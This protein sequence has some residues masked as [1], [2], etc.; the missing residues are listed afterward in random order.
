[1][2]GFII[3]GGQEQHVDFEQGQAL[4]R[5]GLVYW[6]EECECYHIDDPHTWEDID[7]FLNAI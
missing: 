6:C 7:K 3:E 5:Q 1:M 2:E 4:E